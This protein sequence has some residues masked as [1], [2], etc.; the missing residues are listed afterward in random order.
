MTQISV[1]EGDM[2][3]YPSQNLQ[4]PFVLDGVTDKHYVITMYFTNPDEIC[5]SGRKAPDFI[6]QGTGTDLWLQTGQYPHT[7]TFIPRHE[8]NLFSPWVQGK[9]FPKM[10][11]HYWYNISKDMN[12]DSFYPVFLMYNNG[13][14]TGFGWAFVNANLSSLNYEHPD[15]AVFPLFFEEVPECLSRETMFSTMH[16]YLTDNP[17]GLSC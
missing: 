17:Y 9:C 4:P 11:K 1:E 8:I 7:V 16:V 15:K 12:C 6:E 3:S 2:T 14:L 13:E 10:G 5:N